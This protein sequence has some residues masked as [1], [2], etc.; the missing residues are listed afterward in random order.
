MSLDFPRENRLIPP[1]QEKCRL[2]ETENSRRVY[3]W[4]RMSRWTESPAE[5]VVRGPE[6]H[7][8]TTYVLCHRRC[9]RGIR[10]EV[11]P[12]E[13]TTG[14]RPCRATKPLASHLRHE[15]KSLALPGTSVEWFTVKQEALSHLPGSWV[16][17]LGWDGGILRLIYFFYTLHH[18]ILGG[19]LR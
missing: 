12:A 3:Q 19:I 14:C 16:A 9:I 7:I 8:F 10:A 15:K 1:E 6:G 4:R 2:G 13:G 18:S 5:R 11:T 17:L